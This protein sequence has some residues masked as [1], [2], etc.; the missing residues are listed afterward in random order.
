MKTIDIIEKKQF[1]DIDV[2][3]I[4]KNQCF[5]KLQLEQIS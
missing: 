5:F 4:L 3:K 2:Q 1:N